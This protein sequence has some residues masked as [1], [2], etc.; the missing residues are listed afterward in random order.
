MITQT[1]CLQVRE[2]AIAL[3]KCKYRFLWSL[4]RSK[5]EDE[6]GPT[7]DYGVDLREVLPDGFLERTAGIGRVI[8]WAPQNEIL[9]HP[10]TGGFV[11][12]CGWNSI[13]EGIWFGV[14]MAAWPIYAE[15][16]LNAFQ[17]VKEM[18]LATEVRIDYRR[19]LRMDSGVA[20][21]S[22]EIGQGIRAL[23]EESGEKRR[24]MGKLRDISRNVR[25]ERGSSHVALGEFLK[26][27]SA[28]MKKA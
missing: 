13:L 2:I 20:V 1:D 15:Q 6:L 19:D 26:D 12:H 4:R 17:L 18:G 9:G 21:S 16:Q 11:S 24:K 27:V 14:P 3:E 10:S 5:H 25:M 8:G 22:K 23:M 7:S 28:N